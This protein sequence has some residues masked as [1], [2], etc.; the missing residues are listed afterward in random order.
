M[1]LRSR[2]RPATTARPTDRVCWQLASALLSYPDGDLLDRLPPLSGAVTTLPARLADHLQPLLD[3][4]GA[5]AAGG[6]G[7]LLD[8]QARYVDTFD[9]RNRRTL[10]LSWW[11]AGDTRNRGQAILRFVETYRD[12]GVEP[13]DGELADQLCVVLEFAALVAPVAG[14]QL[15]AAHATPL[16]LLHEAV[17]GHDAGYGDVI[18]AVLATVPPPGPDGLR[19]ARRLALAGPPAEAVGLEVYPS[20]PPGPVA[21]GPVAH[22]PVAQ[23]PVAQSPV[24]DVPVA[25]SPKPPGGQR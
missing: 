22:V 23:G 25:L 15:L 21:Q 2:K 4:L 18:A 1:R 6:P 8:A 14:R 17:A 12:A 24:A 20:R 9:L 3:D 13:P 16:T 11:T 19:E 10:F 7:A 5:A